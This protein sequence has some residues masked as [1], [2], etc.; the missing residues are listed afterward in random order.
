MG[1]LALLAAI[2]TLTLGLW[3]LQR[4]LIYFPD[5]RVPSIAVV[6]SGWD[7]VS[8]ETADG[9][10]LTAWYRA[11]EPSQPIVIVFN[12][13]AG[14]RGD[15]APLGRAL[16]DAGFGVLL[17]D[18]RGYGGNPG[19]PT[20]DG[21]ARDARAAI[22]YVAGQL[23]DSQLAYFGESL[24]AAVAIEVATE[25][26]P[27]ALILRSPFTSLVAVGQVHYPWLPVRLLLEDR[28][29]SDERI[30]SIDVPTV[31]IVGDRDSIVP[32]DQSRRI[33]EGLP[34]PK[35]LLVIPGADHNDPALVAGDEV[36]GGIVDFIDALRGDTR[37]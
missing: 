32:I 3:T 25:H 35:R 27:A 17:T 37:A 19:H 2:A 24:G 13:N 14:N 26:E 34:G 22:A 31:V 10:A 30:S 29:S 11:P 7:E 23:P 9:L 36:I 21:L 6:G 4:R 16:A 5:N 20:E 28:Y 18:Y 33:Y 12:G 1:A 8:Y 15:R